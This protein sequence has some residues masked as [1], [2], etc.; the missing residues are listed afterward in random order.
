MARY[1]V[2]FEQVE[3]VDGLSEDKPVWLYLRGT[4]YNENDPE[5]PLWISEV[6]SLPPDPNRN[7]FPSFPRGNAGRFADGLPI[8]KPV[9]N[10]T[11]MGQ[12]NFQLD[13]VDVQPG[14]VLEVMVIMLPMVWLERKTITASE[15]DRLAIGAFGGLLGNFFGGLVG[16]VVGGLFGYLVLGGG[17]QTV[18]VPCFNSVIM[19]R[20]VFTANDL[21]RIDSIGSERFGPRDNEASAACTPI[22]SYYWLSANNRGFSFG[23]MPETGSG[24]CRLEPRITL[25]A[26]NQLE[27]NWADVGDHATDRAWVNIMFTS[28]RSVNV[29]IIEKRNGI[30]DMLTFEQVPVTFGNPPGLFFRNFIDDNS[31]IPRYPNPTCPQCHRFIRTFAF[32]EIEK[33]LLGA[34]MLAGSHFGTRPLFSLKFDTDRPTAP[35]ATFD[36]CDESQNARAKQRERLDRESFEIPVRI[37]DRL[38]LKN[39]AEGLVHIWPAG[40]T[41]LRQ[42]IQPKFDIEQLDFDIIPVIMQNLAVSWLV[43]CSPQ[44]YLASYGEILSN[45][46][47]C[48]TRLRYVHKTEDGH[49]LFDVMLRPPKPFIH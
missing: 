39:V 6:G 13:P 40:T 49:T 8:G 3:L 12:P 20:H 21:A 32:I 29:T 18:E 24:E 37:N 48:V 35:P 1:M 16:N 28:E 36:P 47:V 44:I 42:L 26:K 2:G 10:D 19:A 30:R 9:R 27:G 43:Q 15:F 4:L 17:E 45:G 23:P 46:E 31:Y 25:A 22:D 34:G 7:V 41:P 14:Q 5:N 11:N 33:E 38:Y